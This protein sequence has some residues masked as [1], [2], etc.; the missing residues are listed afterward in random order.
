MSVIE[1]HQPRPNEG[2][3]R[4]G[5]R[6]HWARLVDALAG[7]PADGPG[8]VQFFSRTALY[9][10]NRQ[11]YDPAAR[12]HFEVMSGGLMWPDEFPCG[13]DGP[14]LAVQRNYAGR[15]LLAYRASI[16]VGEERAEFRPVWEQVVRHA[17][18]WPG[19]RPDRRTGRSV[20][21]LKAALRLQ[22]R[23]VGRPGDPAARPVAGTESDGRNRP[24]PRSRG[25]S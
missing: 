13:A 17:P 16:T 12:G 4:L 14:A 23:E 18:D 6:V 20:R 9:V 1:F 2:W 11:R 19:L 15:F 25:T 7:S 22:D 5:A 24:R 10:L 21:R 3:G 8:S